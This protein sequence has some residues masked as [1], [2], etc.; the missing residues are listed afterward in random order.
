[1]V[2][3]VQPHHTTL[4][5]LRV[6]NVWNAVT[7]CK[8]PVW[9]LGW[10]TPSFH[11]KRSGIITRILNRQ[12]SLNVLITIDLRRTHP[13]LDPWVFTVASAAATVTCCM[14]YIMT[15]PERD[16]ERVI[17]ASQM[18][19]TGKWGYLVTIRARPAT[20]PNYPPLPSSPLLRIR[21][22]SGRREN[23]SS[24]ADSKEGRPPF[25][26]EVTRRIRLRSRIIFLSNRSTGQT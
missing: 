22:A 9:L 2:L 16:T 15:I 17:E 19:T 11:F 8:I 13:G 12:S 23:A 18:I 7:S 14:T 1:M 21:S 20:L 5:C 25:L 4:L 24:S 26:Q 10:N 3:N 6:H